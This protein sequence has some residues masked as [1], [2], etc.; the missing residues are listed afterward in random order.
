MKKLL[1][2]LGITV[3]VPDEKGCAKIRQKI[4]GPFG[5]P[6]MDKTSVLQSFAEPIPGLFER[7]RELI[8]RTS[9]EP[10]HAGTVRH[11]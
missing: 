3:A 2:A 7:G 8:G 1:D 5:D 4:P 11:P 10:F 6:R 9:R